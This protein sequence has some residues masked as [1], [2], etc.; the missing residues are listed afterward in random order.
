MRRV[1]LAGLAFLAWTVAFGRAPGAQLHLDGQFAVTKT[2][3]ES[4]TVNLAG[5]AGKPAFLLADVAPGPTTI[6]GQSVPLAFSGAMAVIPLGSIPGSGRIVFPTTVPNLAALDGLTLYFA[7]AVVIGP[8]AGNVDFSNGASLT[9]SAQPVIHAHQATMVG[10]KVILDA[11]AYANA[12]GSAKP[13]HSVL[14]SIVSA[15]VGS[16]ATIVDANRPYARL[17]PD[18][19][20]DYAVKA[21]IVT[22]TFTSVQ[23]A[24]VHAWQ[25]TTSPYSDGGISVLPSFSLTG[26]VSGAAVASFAVDG[27][28]V[29]LAA[30]GSFGPLPV[31]IADGVKTHRTFRISHPD[32]TTTQQRVTFF[33]GFPQPLS[34]SSV[35]SLVA[36]IEKPA[37][38]QIEVLGENELKAA[39]IKNILL[40]LPP[41]QVANDEG[42]FGFTFFSATI[43]FTNLTYNP[44]LDLQ[45]VPTA[46]GIVS[47]VTIHDIRADFDVWGEILEVDYDLSGYMT[48]SPTTITATLVGSASNGQ[49][50]IGVQNVVV[51]RANFDFELNGFFGSVAELFVIESSVKEQVEATI[52]STVASELPAAMAEILNSFTLSGSLLSV[53]DVDLNLA[54][55]ISG[56]VHSTHGVG[57]Q[58]DGKTTVG[59]KE[60]GS[61]AITA[62][63]ATPASPVAFGATTPGGQSYG[64]ALGVAD[65]FLNQVL[66]SATAAGLLDGDLTSLF[67]NT[68]GGPP[69][70]TDQ[71]AILFPQ[72]GFENFPAGTA[73]TLRAHGT[74]PPVLVF[75][76]NGPKTARVYI[77]NLEV[78]FEVALPYSA[79]SVAPLLLVS[80]RGSADVDLTQGLD[81]TLNA[82]IGA[83]TLAVDLLRTYPGADF[84]AIETQTQFL[85]IIFDFALPQIIEAIGTIPLPSLEAQGL[86]L[87]PTQIHLVGANQ[88]SLG[89]FGNL[90]VA[91]A[92]P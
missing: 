53:L 36:Q 79:A 24:V 2:L 9:L 49:L 22:P 67:P 55:P 65:D 83:S 37:L 33:Q 73:I 6:L 82:T 64:A 27:V 77:E 74:V 39:N 81:G 46:G 92:G 56:V 21:T 16:T 7:G 4:L 20:G 86:A 31:T 91:P 26:V 47:T 3:G 70:L 69:L 12:D 43:D 42:P 10:R 63:R 68:G 51:N 54:A 48:T 45:L 88:Q 40:A 34:G 84:A 62:F 41:Q 78:E 71:L 57:I 13:G 35:K 72:C 61:P 29:P 38:D 5:T 11:A 8:S 75:T 90:V 23:S 14:W 44:N 32:G 58:L 52:A 87:Q 25:V 59:V 28:V 50:A 85:G 19:P 76:P 30:N 66:A 15:P 89:L 80:L 60:P 17:T 1:S 18:R